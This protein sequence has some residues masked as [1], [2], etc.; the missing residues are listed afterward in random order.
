[1][2]RGRARL[3]VEVQENVLAKLGAERAAL[4]GPQVG[5]VLYEGAALLRAEAQAA[6][7]AV[8]SG[9]LR[10]GIYVESQYHNEFTPLVRPRRGNRVN[11]PLKDP[12]RTSHQAVV[13]NSVFYTRWVEKGRTPQGDFDVLRPGMR[14]AGRRVGLQGQRGRRASIQAQLRGRPF[15]QRA[16]RR[17]KRDAEALVQRR[18]VELI[19]RTWEK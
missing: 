10:R 3:R 2:G 4:K 11:S 5:R 17:K 15:F 8:D 14:R 16:I 6:V 12:V 7:P 9:N 1:M 19:E 18:L 13:R